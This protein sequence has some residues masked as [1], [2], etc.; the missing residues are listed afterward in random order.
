M[1]KKMEK[2]G[3]NGQ[4]WQTLPYFFVPKKSKYPNFKYNVFEGSFDTESWKIGENSIDFLLKKFNLNFSQMFTDFS[5]LSAETSFFQA[6]FLRTIK[7]YISLESYRRD[8][9][10]EI[11][12]KSVSSTTCEL[13][14]TAA[15]SPLS[16]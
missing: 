8:D 7:S 14:M 3:K 15:R 16:Y 1:A 6:I 9:S 2:N 13:R 12:Y 10:V 11:S 5:I 4:K